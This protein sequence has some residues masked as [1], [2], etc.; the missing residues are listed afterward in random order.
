MEPILIKRYPNRRLYDTQKSKY[1]TLDDLAAQFRE[2]PHQIHVVDSKTGEDLTR[3]ILLQVLLTDLH[4][5]KLNCLPKDFLYTLLTL[6]DSSMLSLFEHYVKMT[7]SSFSVA[8]KA[9]QH[10]LDLFKKL[11]PGPTELLSQITSILN[12]KKE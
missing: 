9:M 1:I 10:N 6:K 7:L 3:R 2:S 4:I 11:A 5:H 12:Q 8:Q